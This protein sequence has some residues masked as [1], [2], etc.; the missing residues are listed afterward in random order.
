MV[1]PY[2]SGTIGSWLKWALLQKLE[3]ETISAKGDL[4]DSLLHGYRDN[5][6]SMYKGG[7][8]P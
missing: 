4:G 7:I 2:C 3:K 1:T 6:L 8:Y 5:V